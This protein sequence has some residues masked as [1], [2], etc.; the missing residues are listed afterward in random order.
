[1][2]MRVAVT[3]GIAEGKSTVMAMIRDH[4]AETLAA[5]DVARKVVADLGVQKELLRIAKISGEFSSAALRTALAENTSTRRQVNAYLHPLIMAEMFS[6]SATFFEVPL[7]I[8][9]CLYRAFERVWVVTCG[10]DEQIKRLKARYGPDCLVE[11]YLSMQLPTV[12]KLAFADAIIRTNQPIEAVWS[13]VIN[14]VEGL[15]AS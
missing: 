9:T 8:E 14:K 15:S 13:V 12:A 4:G 2:F 1:M 7:L 5:D 6:S 11:P 10:I 3:G